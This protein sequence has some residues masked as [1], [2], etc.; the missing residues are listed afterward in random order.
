MV[1]LLLLCKPAFSETFTF[2]VV[3]QFEAQR[4]HDIWQ[5][6]LAE[7]SRRTGHNFVLE[8]SASIPEFE[9]QFQAGEFDF[10]YLNPWH[11]V[12]AHEIQGYEPLIHDGARRLRGVLVVRKDSE[13]GAVTDLQGAEI[14]FPSPNALGASLLMRADLAN[15]F[16]VEI[17]PLYVQTHSSVYLN[18][19][20]GTTPAGGGVMGTLLEQS[21]DVQSE[22]RILYQTREV[23]PH[24]ISV[25]PRVS[26]K[27]AHDVQNA[28]IEMSATP[29]S[30]SLLNLIPIEQTAVTQ[31]GDYLMLED[32]GLREFY[33][34]R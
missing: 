4:L 27:V 24:P 1:W 13:I 22:L 5:P 9:R 3:P 21:S 19:A 14:A 16:H 31:W 18:V 8:G 26:S 10:V 12:I 7:L 15:I 25:H 20:L 30:Q 29:D 17:Q 28:M 32:W 11:A 33:E 23:S 34:T 2:G 6:V